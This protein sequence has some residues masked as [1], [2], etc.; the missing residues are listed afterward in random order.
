MPI[1]F[2]V[3]RPVD[4]EDALT[5]HAINAELAE[6]IGAM[7][8]LDRDNVL[9]AELNP[10]RVALDAW[11]GIKAGTR[12][13]AVTTT[14][15]ARNANQQIFAIPQNDSSPWF[16]DQT[17]GDGVLE[18]EMSAEYQVALGTLLIPPDTWVGITVDGAL[19]GK[20]PWMTGMP[21]V[22]EG[23]NEEIWHQ[24]G[25]NVAVPVAAGTHRIAFVFGI[26][27]G[28]AAA[29]AT[30]DVDLTWNEASYWSREIRR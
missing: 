3:A 18:I 6:V 11:G 5:P 12:T 1:S 24:G 28:Y 30:W 17:T 25:L 16:V 29:G 22:I 8:G 23:E 9:L 2:R 19:V 20:S 14:I 26:H 13:T 21:G 7:H 27:G 10:V 15:D 4:G